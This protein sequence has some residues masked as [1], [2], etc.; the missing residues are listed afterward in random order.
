MKTTVHPPTKVKFPKLQIAI[1]GNIFIVTSPHEGTCIHSPCGD[2][3]GQHL[4]N[5]TVNSLTDFNDSITL[6]N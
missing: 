4:N 6:E 1:N 3:L 2:F 5:L